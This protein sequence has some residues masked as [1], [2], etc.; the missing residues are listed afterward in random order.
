ME[1]CPMQIW[2]PAPV[3]LACVMASSAIWAQPVELTIDD[4][5]VAEIAENRRNNGEI[6]PIAL[7]DVN[8]DGY[9][10]LI[11]G[12]PRAAGYLTVESGGV[13]VRFGGDYFFGLTEEQD[14]RGLYFDLTGAPDLV[15]NRI[16][17]SVIFEDSAGNLPSGV[18]IVPERGGEALGSAVASGDFDGDGFDDIAMASTAPFGSRVGAVYMVFGS[19]DI[20]DILNLDVEIVDERAVEIQG[21]QAEKRFGETLLFADLD[22]DGYD[23]LIIGTP[24]AGTVDIV[25]GRSSRRIYP[26]SSARIPIDQVTGGATRIVSNLADEWFGASLAAGDLTPDQ[27]LVLVVGAPRWP[28]PVN[29]N[30]RVLGFNFGGTRPPSVDLS[31]VPPFFSVESTQS[32]GG[33]GSSVAVGDMTGDGLDDV[34]AGSPFETISSIANAGVVYI[35]SSPGI[36][37]GASLKVPADA[38]SRLVN[39]AEADSFGSSLLF[40]AYDKVFGEDLLV[41]APNY[42]NGSEQDAGAVYIYR[43]GTIPSGTIAGSDTAIPFTRITHS[44]G[45]FRLG[46]H[47]AEGD[48]DSR[49][50]LDVFLSG[51][52]TLGYGPTC[53]SDIQSQYEACHKFKKGVRVYGIPARSV[54]QPGDGLGA[55]PQWLKLR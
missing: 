5:R 25:Y 14:D 53:G 41:G 49:F 13:Y 21:R 36:F 2:K 27:P 40:S 23:D 51:E 55:N 3:V 11:C 32:S 10:D 44:E 54:E 6:G 17:T 28:A 50:E 22:A 20:G 34:V 38:E 4:E 7:G 15:S 37:S 52:G 39:N 46:M 42:D 48:F 12:A 45:G 26:G 33:F 9:D 31:T 24:R 35:L 19:A 43:T 8:G 47:L 29:G 18:Q 1:C 16:F 30:G